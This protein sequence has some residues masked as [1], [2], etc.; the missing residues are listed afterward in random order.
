MIIFKS[1][2]GFSRLGHFCHHY[3]PHV[4]FLSPFLRP[5]ISASLRGAFLRPFS[6]PCLPFIWEIHSGRFRASGFPLFPWNTASLRPQ[7]PPAGYWLAPDLRKRTGVV[8]EAEVTGSPEAPWSWWGWWGRRVGSQ[9]WGLGA[10]PS[11][12]EKSWKERALPRP[13]ALG[14]PRV[15]LRHLPC[16][17]LP[18]G[19]KREW[20]EAPAL[21][22]CPR[23]KG[24]PRHLLGR[25]PSASL[26]PPQQRTGCSCCS[27]A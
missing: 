10:Q 7:L 24:G 12:W 23:M 6:P 22:S 4:T 14:G 17:P 11:L 21:A 5:Y 1:L 19:G 8:E 9:G 27:P 26:S 2:G 13:P 25:G 20:R 3:R 16:R 18:L 15:R